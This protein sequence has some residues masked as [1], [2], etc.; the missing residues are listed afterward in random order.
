MLIDELKSTFLFEK[1]SDAQLHSL[2]RLG[3]EATFPAGETLFREG[4]PADFLWVLLNGEVEL[5]RHVGGQRIVIGTLTRPG[6]YAGG[7]RA[8]T[9]SETS[10][11]YRAT[12]STLHPT[13]LFQ[14]PSRDLGRLLDEWLPMAK[15]LLDGYVSTF[16]SIEVAVRERGRLISLGTLAAGLAHELNNPAAAAKSTLADLRAVVGRLVALP[17]WLANG[18]LTS[19]RFQAIQDLQSDAIARSTTERTLGAI[20]TGRREEEIGSWLEDHEVAN[21]WD[22]APTFVAAGLDL[23]WLD[24]ATQ[25]LGANGLSDALSWVADTLLAT[26]LLDQLDDAT[27]RITQLVSAV[28]DYSYLDRS[29]EQE[30]DIHDGI[31][32]TLI[33]LGHKLRPGVE[34]IRDYDVHLPHVLAQGSELNQV[35]TNLIDNAIDAMDGHGQLRI[36]THREEHTLLVEIIDQGAGIPPELGAHVFDPFFTTK[37]VGKGTGLGLDIVRRI[38][39]DRCNGEISFESVPGE[40]RFLVRLPL[41]S[42]QRISSRH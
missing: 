35:W 12:G 34:V 10:G 19:A 21:P 13:R 16:E 23:S 3:T 5:S 4:Q 39:V 26:E 27:S 1:L 20:E 7:V 38:V 31:E 8:F 22:L 40:T 24:T 17:G 15:H 33:I 42:K 6:T 18:E 14:L 32:K 25:M 28:K 2:A 37:E 29:A 41:P 11:S 9:T 30:I 36:R